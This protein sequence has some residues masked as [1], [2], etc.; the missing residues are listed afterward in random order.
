MS[1]YNNEN[2]VSPIIATLMLIMITLIAASGLAMI[3]AHLQEDHADRVG[4]LTAID[5]EK[6][7]IVNIDLA[8]AAGT[9]PQY[10]E[11]NFINITI[12]NLDIKP[13]SI[14][15]ITINDNPVR[16][17]TVKDK[18]GRL[19]NHTNRLSIPGGRHKIVKINL[20]NNLTR[21][22]T[23]LNN[24]SIHIEIMTSRV[25]MFSRVFTPPIVV[26]MVQMESKIIGFNTTII[27]NT[28]THKPIFQDFLILDASRSFDPDDDGF[29]ISHTW[30]V[31]NNTTE[32]IYNFNL[33]G[34]MVRPNLPNNATNVSRSLIT[35]DNTGMVSKSKN[36]TLPGPF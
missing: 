14:L 32:P 11:L 20:L 19:F 34:R 23:I 3:S 17:Y 10:K 36:I 25:N 12:H 13:A 28:T 8:P 7:R 16:N 27:N 21:N 18:T 1:F 35:K 30:G 22:E 15:G 5:G 33:S 26:P 2:G 31:W 6:L 4:L 29:I 24:E 9:P